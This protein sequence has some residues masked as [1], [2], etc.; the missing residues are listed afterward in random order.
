MSKNFAQVVADQRRGQLSE[1][2]GEEFAKLV[3][4]VNTL[5]KPAEFNL[6]IKLV[7]NPNTGMIIIQDELVIKRPKIDRAADAMFANDEG[8]LQRSDPNQPELPGLRSVD[9]PQREVVYVEVDRVSGEI[10]QSSTKPPVPQ[11][12]TPQTPAAASA[13]APIV[14]PA[15]PLNL[16]PTPGEA[17]PPAAAA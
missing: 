17:L 10:L 1:Q 14:V 12:I 7:P 2:A 13:I 16:A 5:R 9:A 8:T 3:V 6:K 15:T 11:P 4:E